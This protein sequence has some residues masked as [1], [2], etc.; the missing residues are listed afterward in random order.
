V[1][2]EAPDGEASEAAP[3]GPRDVFADDFAVTLTPDLVDRACRSAARAAGP[4]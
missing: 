3:S 1:P 2:V 4:P